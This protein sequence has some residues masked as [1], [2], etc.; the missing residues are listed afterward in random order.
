MIP[1]SVIVGALVPGA[2]N[3]GQKLVNRR[4]LTGAG[5][6]ATRNLFATQGE[7]RGAVSVLGL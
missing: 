6:E 3:F 7:I 4:G 2:G 1:L 5:A